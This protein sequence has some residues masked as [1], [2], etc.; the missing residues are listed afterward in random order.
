MGDYMFEKGLKTLGVIV[1][2]LFSFFYTDKVVT[3]VKNQDPIMIKIIEF[4]DIYNIKPT[5]A[6]VENINIIPGINGCMVDIKKS[7]S[8]MKKIG[9][10]NSNMIEYKEIKPD[11]SLNNIYDKYIVKGNSNTN[12]LAL[13]FKINTINHLQELLFI[14]KEKDIKASFFIDGKDIEDNVNIIYQLI[15]E[16]HELYN[17]GYSNNYDKDLIRWTN[18]VI[19]NISNNKSNYCL[20]LKENQEVLDICTE[21]KMHTVKSNIV[22][23]YSNSFSS[24]KNK[25]EKGSIIVFDVNNN[26][27]GELL[28]LIQF[29][30]RRGFKFNLLSNHLSEE[31]C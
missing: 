11:I 10:Y 8:N 13:V 12:V 9:T 29:F 22:I 7:Y 16:Q 28:K 15:N 25:I 23:N 1:L 20:V 4:E 31:G 5:N 3:V 24:V 19:D 30:K 6:L 27:K 2:C 17:L 26:T 18:N 21:N 14:L